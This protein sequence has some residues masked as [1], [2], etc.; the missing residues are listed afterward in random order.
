MTPHTVHSCLPAGS[1]I[2]TRERSNLE[3]CAWAMWLS[4]FQIITV[5]WCCSGDPPIVKPSLFAMLDPLAREIMHE[6]PADSLQVHTNKLE[7]FD[8]KS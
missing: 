2:S 8:N 1:H 5:I 7:T 3:H 6:L 4:R